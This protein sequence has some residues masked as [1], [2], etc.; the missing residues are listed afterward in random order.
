M[1]LILLIL[2]FS[3]I[4]GIVLTKDKRQ[5][6]ESIVED[7]VI[8]PETFVGTIDNNVDVPSEIVDLI[9]NYND[10]YYSSIYSLIEPN[11]A[12]YFSDEIA[13][14]ISDYSIKLMVESRKLYDFDFTLNKAH[15]DLKFT[16]YYLD[17]NSIHVDF[18]MDDYMNFSFL[19]DICS[20][21]FDIE[22]SMIISK[23]DDGYKIVD[24]DKTQGYYLMFY[25]NKF[26]SINDVEDIYA[27]YLKQLNS[28]IEN[29]HFL[30]QQLNSDGYIA[31]KTYEVPYDRTKAVAYA[32]KYYHS[33]NN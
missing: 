11:T 23:T 31:K 28:A 25:E 13:G 8:I 20:Q 27:F 5:I 3:T 14:A 32:D 1:V 30:K 2:L 17:G 22:N 29:E 18:L 16:D 33:R 15:Y 10:D 26:N 4:I 12:K 9:I 7:V 19:G 6:E 24:Y 21:S